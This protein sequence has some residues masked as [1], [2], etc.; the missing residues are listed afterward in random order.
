MKVAFNDINAYKRNNLYRHRRAFNRQGV[1]V[2]LDEASYIDFSGNDYLGLSQH[3]EIKKAFAE[4]AQALGFGSTASAMVSGLSLAT[5][6]LENYFANLTGYPACLFFNSGYHANLAVFSVLGRS[7]GTIIA[8]KLIHA[9]IIDGVKLSGAKLKRF[10]HQ[11]MQS[12]DKISQILQAPG[13]C[14][15]EGIFSMDGDITPLPL[16]HE[17]CRQY[18]HG[19]IVDD[20]HG[21][22]VL[23]EN[24]IGSLDHHGLTAK[25]VLVY[26]TPFG[27][28]CGGVGAMVCSSKK[29]I[30]Q[31]T[32]FS[33]SY[34]YSTALP[35]AISQ[36][37]YVAL[38][39]VKQSNDL[40]Q[41]LFENIVFFNKQ[42]E[43]YGFQLSASDSTPIRSVLI[44]EADKTYQIQQRLMEKGFLVSCIRPPTV[45]EK[46]CRLRISLTALHEK[47][48]IAS[49]FKALMIAKKEIM[50]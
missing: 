21:F 34:M 9:S 7:A 24:G 5:Q 25:E 26:I 3:P 31:L 22:G 4:S 35:P 50:I 2:C 49:L 43:A 37:L 30:E 45:P 12:L 41:K 16:L 10:L 46:T 6:N 23:G 18:G 11:D 20:A 27:K 29:I 28:A 32:Q 48:H 42:A 40:R 1:C 38:E 15:T 17:N 39:L 14:A 36:T 33:R 13:I 8:D 19:L 47:K 44:G